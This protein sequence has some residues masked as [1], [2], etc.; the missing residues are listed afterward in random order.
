METVNYKGDMFEDVYR[1]DPFN[2]KW[3]K[4]ANYTENKVERKGMLKKVTRGVGF[5]IPGKNFGYIGFGIVPTADPRAQED[6]WEYRP[7]EINKK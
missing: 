1:Y 4:V 6:L 2:N 3:H 7:F 5:T